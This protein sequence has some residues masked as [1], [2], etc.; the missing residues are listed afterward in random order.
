MEN[1]KNS[2][3]TKTKS[4]KF[5][6]K[7]P[8]PPPLVFKSF[9]G[10]WP[11]INFFL[12]SGLNSWL[13]IGNCKHFYLRPINCRYDIK[14]YSHLLTWSVVINQLWFN[15]FLLLEWWSNTCTGL[16]LVIGP[17]QYCH[18]SSIFISLNL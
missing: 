11:G 4:A 10:T 1:I 15:L 13:G 17:H 8:P 3:N 12:I 6:L 9:R 14:I 16:G 5:S 2:V 18:M 7:I